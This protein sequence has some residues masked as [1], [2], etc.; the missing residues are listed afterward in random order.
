[1]YTIHNIRR[2]SPPFNPTFRIVIR[3]YIR[4]YEQQN[5]NM[6]IPVEAG[7]LHAEVCNL[8][9]GVDIVDTYVVQ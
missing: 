2:L 6:K 3:T 4:M 9:S 1:M 8:L 5:L 7:G